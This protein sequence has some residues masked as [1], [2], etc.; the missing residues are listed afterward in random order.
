[1]P[2]F[3]CDLEIKSHKS[4]MKPL[5]VHG[6]SPTVRV[7]IFVLLSIVLM[8]IDHRLGYLETIRSHLST[9]V[10]PIQYVV[11]LP[12]KVGQWLSKGFSSRI[13]LLTENAR[14]H[15]ENLQLQIQLQKFQDLQKEN[16]RLRRLLNSS[17]K[18]GEQVLIAEVLAVD[19]D[20]F[21]RKLQINKGSYHGVFEGQP[22]M[23][24][25]GVMGQVIHI[26]LLSSI[27]MLITDPSHA[28]PVQVVSS[29]LRTIAEG[30]G[31]VNR[32][33][34][35]Y[36]PNNA[37]IKVGD[38]LVTSG[39]GGQFPRGYPV[40]MVTEVNPDIGQPYAQ[41]QAVPMASLER[42]REV[43]LVWPTEETVN[44]T[45]EEDQSSKP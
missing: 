39:F 24:A 13:H 7:I 17:V 32:L 42:N 2:L 11:N 36:L 21:R 25:Q 4:S 26:G 38:L 29:G 22:V 23:D 31:A 3:L 45:T 33:A 43:L 12:V 44:K 19:V 41:V 28:L 16:E 27:V 8:T 15:E 40:G 30:M 6:P 1:M 18:M 34:L 35:L 14:L 5:F 37:E 20:P 9:L 10:Y